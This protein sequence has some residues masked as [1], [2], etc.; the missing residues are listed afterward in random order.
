MLELRE[1]DQ[2]VYVEVR[3]SADRRNNFVYS[4][5]KRTSLATSPIS[6]STKSFRQELQ[7]TLKLKNFVNPRPVRRNCCSEVFYLIDNNLKYKIWLLQMQAR[8]KDSILM[9]IN[10]PITQKGK[11]N[12]HAIEQ[13]I[14]E[15]L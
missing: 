4:V 9:R 15:K 11:N 8:Y 12:S 3:Y 5:D 10:H 2:T 7:A 6:K 1:K 14:T 13:V